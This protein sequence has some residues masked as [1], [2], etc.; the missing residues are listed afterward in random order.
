M[1]NKIPPKT[2][3][4][5][6]K[7][8]DY[9]VLITIL[10][11]ISF[12]MLCLGCLLNVLNLIA[13]VLSVVA[14]IFAYKYFEN[15]KKHILSLCVS[16]VIVILSVF[17]MVHSGVTKIENKLNRRNYYYF[18]YPNTNDDFYDDWDFDYDFD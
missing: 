6:N 17:M 11:V 3:Q 15:D 5:K 14:F 16:V 8:D 13:I 4:D 7:N 9:L 10:L 2:P 12:I 18:E 1:D